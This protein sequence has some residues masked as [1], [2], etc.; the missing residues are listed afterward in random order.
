[1]QF[2]SDSIQVHKI[3]EFKVLIF[4]QIVPALRTYHLRNSVRTFPYFEYKT[5][6]VKL[7]DYLY[8][9]MILYSITNYINHI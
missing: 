9:F 7:P 2:F 5:V 3:H 4:S 6:T 8:I 1:M